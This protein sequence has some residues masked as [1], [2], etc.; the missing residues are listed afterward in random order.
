M[1]AETGA[2]ETAKER[3]PNVEQDKVRGERE[4]G[5][6]GMRVTIATQNIQAGGWGG[7]RL[8]FDFDRLP[9]LVE[10]LEPAEV[11]ILVVNEVRD[12]RTWCPGELRPRTAIEQA[13]HDR[14]RMVELGSA[15]GLQLAGITPSKTGTP[16]AVL[17]RKERFADVSWDADVSE[18]LFT[19]GCGVARFSFP[20]SKEPLA[21]AALHASPWSELR[22]AEELQTAVTMVCE[23]SGWAVVAGNLNCVPAYGPIPIE[24]LMRPHERM[25]Y[26]T[27]AGG[28]GSI[29][30]NLRPQQALSDAGFVDV[31]EVLGACERAPDEML[32]QLLQRCLTS[33][34]GRMDRI[35]VS[36]L[37][38]D[39]PVEY[40]LLDT[41]P[42]A[43]EYHGVTVTLDLANPRKATGW[44]R[45]WSKRKKRA[46]FAEMLPE[47]GLDE[48]KR[49]LMAEV[50]K[51][52]HAKVDEVIADLSAM[53]ALVY[54][55]ERAG[56]S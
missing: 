25:N 18:A 12:R 52:E 35:H 16:T 36:G 4:E 51:E 39:T 29:T 20:D 7:R 5:N 34:S 44:A 8:D 24:P 49:G 14:E 32:P 42:E 3:Q 27:G 19:N 56:G 38:A 45:E 40:R 9:W 11:D 55:E 1:E 23:H 13:I 28:T 47:G 53:S 26:L 43:S 33:R 6:S 10:R 50:P 46:V 17:Y 41:P 31:A 22:T 30:R 15:L 37:L 2:N 54:E 48:L 21:V